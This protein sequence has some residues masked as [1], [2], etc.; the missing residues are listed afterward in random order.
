[1]STIYILLKYLLFYIK[2]AT[3]RILNLQ[4]SVFYEISN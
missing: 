4:V 3:C 2:C 1:M